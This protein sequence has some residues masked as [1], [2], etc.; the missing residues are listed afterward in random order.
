MICPLP[1]QQK[2]QCSV[3]LSGEADSSYTIIVKECFLVHVI[4]QIEIILLNIEG[5]NKS[6]S[7]VIFLNH[8]KGDNFLGHPVS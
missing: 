6:N 2:E 1:F 3:T 7:F 8:L 5:L 4:F